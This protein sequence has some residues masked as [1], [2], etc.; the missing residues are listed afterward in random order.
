VYVYVLDHDVHF[1]V[2]LRYMGMLLALPK[3][4]AATVCNLSLLGTVFSLHHDTIQVTLCGKYLPTSAF[5]LF[6][7]YI[8]S[9]AR[10]MQISQ[11]RKLPNSGN[12]SVSCITW[13]LFISFLLLLMHTYT[14]AW[15]QLFHLRHCLHQGL[16]MLPVSPKHQCRRWEPLKD[17]QYHWL[18]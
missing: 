9:V 1:S 12:T 15:H 16:Q 13:P 4:L 8:G 6:S 11:L 18:W 2:C 5:E 14:W 10:L 17:L 3:R 7:F